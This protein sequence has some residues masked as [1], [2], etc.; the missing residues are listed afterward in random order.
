VVTPAVMNAIY[1]ATGKPGAQPATQ[2][3]EARAAAKA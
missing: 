2:E 1:A 3:R